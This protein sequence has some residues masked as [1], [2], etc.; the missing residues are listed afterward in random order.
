VL[1]LLFFLF[2]LYLTGIAFL[3]GAELDALLDRNPA[4]ETARRPTTDRAARATTR[5]RGTA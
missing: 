3:Q 5:A 4:A 2:F 1:V